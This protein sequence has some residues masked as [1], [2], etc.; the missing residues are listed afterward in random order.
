MKK[1]ILFVAA[2]VLL[3]YLSENVLAEH[4]SIPRFIA[5][6]ETPG[7]KVAA[8]NLGAALG[9][10]TTTHACGTRSIGLLPAANHEPTASASGFQL[11]KSRAELTPTTVEKEA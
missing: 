9:G 4:S 2:F 3:S 11:S 1:F 5:D 8:V 6:D 10:S 7:Y